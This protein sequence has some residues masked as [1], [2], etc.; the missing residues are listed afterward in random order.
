M[1]FNTTKDKLSLLLTTYFQNC[2]Q[3]KW[4]SLMMENTVT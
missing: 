3:E 2:Q 4:Q 1:N